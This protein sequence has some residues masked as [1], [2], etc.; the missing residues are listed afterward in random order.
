MSSNPTI[1]LP[2]QPTAA[3]ATT[4]HDDVSNEEH[5]PLQ[6]V[7]EEFVGNVQDPNIDSDAPIFQA[8]NSRV[9]SIEENLI[10]IQERLENLEQ[11]IGFNR[12]IPTED[13]RRIKRW[14]H[15][16]SFGLFH[17]FYLILLVS[18]VTYISL[19]NKKPTLFFISECLTKITLSWVGVS[20]M[21]TTSLNEVGPISII[22]R[23]IEFMYNCKK[24]FAMLYLATMLGIFIGFLGRASYLHR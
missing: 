2:N 16:L 1:H 12:E 7:N 10:E 20:V 23:A 3:D 6:R 19:Q 17:L 24:T 4:Q 9:N 15:V 22:I 5:I 11:T 13:L 21:L 8:E 18:Q 14:Y